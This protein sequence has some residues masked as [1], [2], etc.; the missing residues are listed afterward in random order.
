MGTVV[1]AGIALIAGLLVGLALPHGP[2]TQAQAILV[3]VGGLSVGLLGGLAMPSRWAMLIVPLAH[4]IAIEIVRWGIAGPSVGAIR[5]DNMYGVLALVLGRGFYAF[6]AMVPM[7]AGARLGAMFAQSWPTSVLGWVPAGVI[8]LALTALTVIIM[9]PASTPPILGVDGKPIAGS[10]ASLEKIRLGGADQWIMVRA[11]NPDKPVLLYL[12]G[13]PGQSDLPYS[14]VMFE[15]LSRDFVVVGWDQRGTGK[16]S[17]AIDPVSALTLDQAIADTLE[18]SKYLR[19]RFDEKKIYLMG[20]SW[21]STLG[22]LAVQRQPELYFAWI[23]SGQMV[24]QRETD[25]RLYQDVLTLADRNADVETAKKMR[26]FG[27]PPYADIPYAHAF[28]MGQYDKLYKPYTPPQAYIDKGNAAKLGP[29][30]VFASEYNFVEKFNVLRGLLDMFSIMYP[31]LQHIDFH[32]DVP[33]LDVP[34]YILDG[35]AELTARREVMLEW[36]DKLEAPHKHMASFENAAHSVAFEQFEA[37]HKL[38][39]NTVLQE[40]YVQ[41][42]IGINRRH[43]VRNDRFDVQTAGHEASHQP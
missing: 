22:V 14:R 34:V 15:D 33:R 1:A 35:R 39:M 36:F 40:T 11:H 21:G 2:T 29:Y 12:S 37:F 24:S 28:V 10:I 26:A 6:V 23:G 27:E 18:L 20:E 8:G 25:R 19:E 32:R 5:L 16:S 31:Q 13:G 7:V 38:M 41:S 43:L 30:G 17:A 42:T 4:I 3:L 9:L